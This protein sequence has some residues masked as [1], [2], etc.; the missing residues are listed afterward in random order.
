MELGEPRERGKSDYGATKHS[1]GRKTSRKGRESD[2]IELRVSFGTH[3]VLDRLNDRL[4]KS[5]FCKIS[6]I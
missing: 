5:Q 1:Q 2:L 6:I 3:R 4:S